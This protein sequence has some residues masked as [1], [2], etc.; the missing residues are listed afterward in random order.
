MVEFN[1]RYPIDELGYS[2]SELDKATRYFT[3]GKV[4][5]F[6]DLT[7]KHAKIRTQIYSLFEKTKGQFFTPPPPGFG[8]TGDPKKSL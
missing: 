2:E 1:W 6:K 7:I 8:Y 5:K 3:K 4:K